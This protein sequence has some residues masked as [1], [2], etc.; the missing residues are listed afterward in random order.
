MFTSARLSLITQLYIS[1]ISSQIQHSQIRV[2][3][4]HLHPIRSGETKPPCV[5]DRKKPAVTCDGVAAAIALREGRWMMFVGKGG[6]KSGRYIKT[7]LSVHARLLVLPKI[8]L[9]EYYDTGT[10]THQITVGTSIQWEHHST[11]TSVNKLLDTD[12]RYITMSSHGWNLV[13][14]E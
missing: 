13:G 5:Q 11:W 7:S 1:V 6:K 12:T 10:H 9:W 8:G 4:N 14:E 3:V 2:V